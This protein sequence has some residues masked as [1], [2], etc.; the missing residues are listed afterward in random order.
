MPRS[1]ASDQRLHCLLGAIFPF[2]HNIFD[3]S[4][5]S[6]VKLHIHLWNVA[7]I[8]F[9]FS[10]VFLIYISIF[11]SHI[12]LWYVVRISPFPQYFF[13]S[14]SSGV[15]LHIIFWNVVRIYFPFSTI[16]S[17]YLYLQESNYI[18]ISE[19]WWFD[20]FIPKFCKSDMSRYGYLEVFQSP[21]DFEITKV[22][23]IVFLLNVGTP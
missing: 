10:T 5:F 2:F 7:R 9:L 17:I 8:Y 21:M 23:S 12:H 4:L 18:F 15:K 16:I 22:D 6:R 13:I 3:T 14:L 1:A 11:R 19:M 20:L